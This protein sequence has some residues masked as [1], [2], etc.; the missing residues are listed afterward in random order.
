MQVDDWL[1]HLVFEAPDGSFFDEPYRYRARLDEAVAFARRDAALSTF[2]RTFRGL[3][4]IEIAQPAVS[5]ESMP[6]SSHVPTSPVRPLNELLLKHKFEQVPDTVAPESPRH[7]VDLEAVAKF[8][9]WD[10][11]CAFGGATEVG[12]S[13]LRCA[14]TVPE[15]AKLAA[16]SLGEALAHQHQLFP[17][18]AHALPWLLSLLESP[19]VTC[20]PTLAAWLEVIA[21]SASDARDAVSRVVAFTARLVARDL[22]SAMKAHQ[23]CAKEVLAA[24]RTLEPRLRALQNDPVI[25]DR[26]GTV[27]SLL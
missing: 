22:A 23:A 19:L 24:L 7:P 25:G 16:E 17:V 18:T 2:G 15:E 8:P 27:L 1:I 26:L 11:Q 10:F 20:R 5:V 21:D 6:R 4:K 9:W 12:L 14:S 13:L 3:S